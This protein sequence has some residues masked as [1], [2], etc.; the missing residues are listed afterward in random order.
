MDYPAP[1][2]QPKLASRINLPSVLTSFVG[3]EREQRDITAALAS[4]RLLTLT[5]AGGCGKTRLAMRV[6][7]QASDHYVDGVFWVELAQLTD[8]AL[9][10]QAVADAVG[11]MLDAGAHRPR[12][13]WAHSLGPSYD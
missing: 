3:R 5:G 8:P 11:A 9:A 7:A 2:S 4:V 1:K 10:P 13:L 12:R 6:A